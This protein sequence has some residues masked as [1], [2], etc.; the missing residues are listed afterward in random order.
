MFKYGVYA[1]IID[2]DAVLVR[3]MFLVMR[4]SSTVRDSVLTTDQYSVFSS[5]HVTIFIADVCGCT[6]LTDEAFKPLNLLVL[7]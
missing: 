4:I 3:A 7:C 6:I 1:L 2:P 5:F